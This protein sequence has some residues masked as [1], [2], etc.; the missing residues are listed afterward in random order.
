MSEAPW[1]LFLPSLLHI[2]FS[3]WFGEVFLGK[4]GCWVDP[5][6]EGGLYPSCGC[7]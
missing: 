1:D 5:S 3:Q 7:P 6:P 4:D 2:L